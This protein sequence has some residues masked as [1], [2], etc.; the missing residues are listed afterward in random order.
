MPE[1]DDHH[2]IMAKHDD[3]GTVPSGAFL[4][5]AVLWSHMQ[6]NLILR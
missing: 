2:W 3:P 1:G 5:I 6:V 4:G